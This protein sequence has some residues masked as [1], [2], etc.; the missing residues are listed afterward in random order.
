MMAANQA[1]SIFFEYW[2]RQNLHKTI[3]IGP[4]K[5]NTVRVKISPEL[6]SGL[7]LGRQQK[8]FTTTHPNHGGVG[9][10][11]RRCRLVL[12]AANP[13]PNRQ[14]E[15]ASS[16][17]AAPLR[18]LQDPD[19]RLPETSGC[20]LLIHATDAGRRPLRGGDLRADGG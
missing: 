13:A 19:R 4:C 7:L 8:G 2:V 14:T 6:R 12:S 20:G 18:S 9:N 16:P 5:I 17:L 15:L 10:R 3:A 1:V 11:G